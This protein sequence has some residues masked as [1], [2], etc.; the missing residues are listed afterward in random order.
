MVKKGVKKSAKKKGRSTKISPKPLPM[1]MPARG[2]SCDCNNA[3]LWLCRI[4]LIATVLFVLSLI[5]K[6]AE[7]VVGVSWWIWLVVAIIFGLRP[8]MKA[9]GRR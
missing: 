5:P 6:V 4:A 3:D 2:N 9:M 1:R 7:W 8:L